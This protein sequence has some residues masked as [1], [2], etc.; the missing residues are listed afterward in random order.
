MEVNDS[1]N[2]DSEG[3]EEHGRENVNHLREYLKSQTIGGNIEVKD[4]A[5]E[6]QKEMRNTLL[7]IRGKESSVELCPTVMQ[8]VEF[9]RYG[10]NIQLRRFPAKE[11]KVQ[12]G[13]FFA[14][15]GKM[16]ED[17]LKETLLN[18]KEPKID[19]LGNSQLIQIVKD[20]KT[21][22]FT[23]RKTC[24]KGKAKS[25]AGQHFANTSER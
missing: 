16:Q 13:Y 21:K 1:A 8:K 22:M 17:N 25:V 10:L 6:A 20:A 2:K 11:L 19:D 7:E 18:R 4:T 12:P 5:T 14:A 3:S 24:F 9:V 15:Y 23:I